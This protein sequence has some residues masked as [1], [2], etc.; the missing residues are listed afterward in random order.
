MPQETRQFFMCPPDH[1]RV[2][3]A[4]NAWTD[5][6]AQV[7]PERA[8]EQWERLYAAYVE[9]GARV[10]IIEPEPGVPELVFAGDSIFLYGERAISSRFRHAE[11][12]P[13]VAPMARRFARRGYRPERLPDGM[14]FEGN[15]EALHWNGMLLAGWGVRSDR[16]A[17]E[18]VSTL[19]DLELHAF[20]LAAPFYHFDVC[21]APIDERTALYYPGAFSAQGR[22]QLAR[23]VPRLIAVDE[24]E[25]KALACNSVSVHGT[26]VMSTTQAPRVAELLC[27]AGK[28]VVALEVS[29]FHKAGGGVK[30]LTLEAY[31]PASA[32]RAVA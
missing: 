21:F 31:H 26:V 18:H 15:A 30:C 27:A 3:Y 6:Q 1:F 24:R 17:L 5:P 14:H 29:E 2:D 19:L 10:G 13:E 28:R 7:D 16:G 32:R 11:R 22:Q 9:A 4:I 23:L 20:Q 25:A 8:L 12:E